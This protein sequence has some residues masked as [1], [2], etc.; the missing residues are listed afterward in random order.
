VGIAAI[1]LQP[2]GGNVGIGTTDPQTLFTVSGANQA[3]GGAFNTYGNVL[4]T[5]NEGPAIN[6]GGSFSLGGRYWTGNTTIATFGRIHGKKEDASDG[7]TAG[8]LSFETT[9]EDGA[10][11]FER[12][13][14]TST[15]NVG[16]GTTNT[17]TEA[18]LFLGAQG[19]V[20]G[21]Q[22]V[23]QKGTSCSCA[24][25][26]DNFNDSFRIMSGTNTGSTAV[27][28]SINHVNGIATFSSTI[29]APL[30]TSAANSISITGTQFL[31]TLATDNALYII[32]A[33]P[34]AGSGTSA[35]ALITSRTNQN[36]SVQTIVSS[37]SLSFVT[38]GYNL[39]L[40]SNLAY[41]MSARWGIIRLA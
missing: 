31:T 30:I 4:I 29:C 33:Q 2:S 37:S 17:S 14:I 1:S 35:A 10:L 22:L 23:L 32:T 8:Y 13:R 28:M 21:G 6:R 5:S 24:T 36:P 20:E 12:M 38:S 40:C 41:G 16:I 34:E 18:N 15:G 7:S 26:L 9:R 39:C 27:N 11:L 3:L 25:H 19:T